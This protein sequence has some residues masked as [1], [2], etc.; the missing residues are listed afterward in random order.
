MLP[1]STAFWV[2][3]ARRL[4]EFF[5]GYVDYNDCDCS[6]RDYVVPDRPDIQ[7]AED[8]EQWEH[9]QA[10]KLAVTPLSKEEIEKA[11]E[12]SSYRVT[13]A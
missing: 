6:E 12:Y 13:H 11:A 7:H 9:F 4:V 8:G 1:P 10:R 5:G 3:A 2:A